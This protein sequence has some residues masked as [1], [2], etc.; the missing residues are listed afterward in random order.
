MKIN[1]RRKEITRPELHKALQG[2][3]PSSAVHSEYGMT[4]LLSQAW[5][6]GE[7]YFRTPPW[8]KVLIRE[9]NDPLA[10]CGTGRTGGVSVIDMANLYS[11]SFIATQDL[12]RTRDNGSFEI[13]GRFDSSELRGCSLMVQE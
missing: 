3:F 11:C 13:L 12:G 6:T 2:A 10:Y 9:V 4:E 7:G 8:M 1:F 5:S